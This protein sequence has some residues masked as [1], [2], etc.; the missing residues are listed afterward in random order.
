MIIIIISA[1]KNVILLMIPDG[2]KSLSCC[3]KFERIA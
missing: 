1:K 3:E 2:E